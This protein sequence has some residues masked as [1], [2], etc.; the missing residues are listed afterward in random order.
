MMRARATSRA[1]GGWRL[2]LPLLLAGCLGPLGAEEVYDLPPL[3]YTSCAPDDRVAHLLRDLDAGSVQLAW[4]RHFGYLPALLRELAVPLSSQVLVF[5]KTSLQRERISPD[6]PRALYFNDE[7]YVGTVPGGT[8]IE[9]AAT[10]P[11]QGTMFYVLDQV[12]H[13]HP[14]LRRETQECLRC[15]DLPAFTGGFPGL[16]MRSVYPDRDGQ[17]LLNLGSMITT[18][19]S[20]WAKRWGGWYVTGSHGGMRQ[21]GNRIYDEH[22]DI[23]A[24][25]LVAGANQP[26]LP[27]FV[28]SELYLRPTSDVVALLALSHQIEVHNLI[29]SSGFSARIALRDEQ[30]MNQALGRPAGFRSDST[31]RRLVSAADAL[32][33]G[34][35]YGDEAPFTDRVA[36]SSGF[37]EDF[38]RGGV[39]DSR[40][41][42]LRE[43]DLRRHFARLP[44]SY[45]IHSQAFACL[46]PPLKVVVYDR[47]GEALAGRGVNARFALVGSDACRDI[48][49]LLTATLGDLPVDW[50]A[51]PTTH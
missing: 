7:V 17:P 38:A 31:A 48:T 45:L 18:P 30:V 26:T 20:P 5:S 43:L 1:E 36:G 16:I 8:L 46:P 11:R 19:A 25:D 40:G 14:R 22:A 12:E 34:L 3:S 49:R 51:S 44:C 13:A 23:D 50:P 10:D 41:A 33:R 9:L 47:L 27:T 24:L 2:L 35:L 6:T 32:V 42:S 39:R 21:L 4:D 37:A 29:T 15:H 28:D